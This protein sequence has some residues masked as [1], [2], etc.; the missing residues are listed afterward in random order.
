MMLLVRRSTVFPYTSHQGH[1]LRT[2]LRLLS[3][4]GGDGP[5]EASTTFYEAPLAASIKSLKRVSVTTA[6]LS[7]AIPPAVFFHGSE[8]VPLSGQ[9]AITGITMFASLGSTAAIQFLFSPYVLRM[10]KFSS[11]SSAA[12]EVPAEREKA[13][14]TSRLKDSIL[15]A[16]TMTFF[17]GEMTSKF[18]VGDAQKRPE[19]SARPFVSF[20]AGGRPYFV[21]ASVFEDKALLRQLLGRP[22]KDTEK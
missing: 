9:I 2:P 1:A 5:Q 21:H 19:G 18:K 7:L 15:E 6:A 22:L 4:C 13:S 10:A 11:D 16:T 8:S 20:T 3:Q 12:V 14:P 17:G